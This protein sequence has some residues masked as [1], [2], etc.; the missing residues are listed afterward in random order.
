MFIFPFFWLC[1]WA[2]NVSLEVMWFRQ[3]VFQSSLRKIQ[4]RHLINTF[5]PCV[6]PLLYIHKLIFCQ[7]GKNDKRAAVTLSRLPCWHRCLQKLQV[8]LHEMQNG[9]Y[10]FPCCLTSVLLQGLESPAPHYQ[11]KYL[12]PISFNNATRSGVF[13]SVD[14]LSLYWIHRRGESVGLERATSRLPLAA[15]RHDR[16]CAEI[17]AQ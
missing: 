2:L 5:R 1:Q 10:L 3:D 9:E 14:C 17:L 15:R 7:K 13:A 8:C 16:K 4:R 6:C 11:W 12:L